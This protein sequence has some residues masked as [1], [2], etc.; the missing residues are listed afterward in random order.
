[1]LQP[2]P[3]GVHD[4]HIHIR[5]ACTYDEIVQGCD[6][7]GPERSWM[8]AAAREHDRTEDLV[9]SLFRPITLPTLVTKD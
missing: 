5:T 1:M 8:H 3:G 7:S 2:H 4:D 6:P 9:V